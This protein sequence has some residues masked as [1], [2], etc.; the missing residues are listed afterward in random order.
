[1]YY[2][3]WRTAIDTTQKF[4]ASMESLT[5]EI[6]NRGL[7]TTIKTATTTEGAPRSIVL[8]L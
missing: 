7:A 2:S 4:D 5:R 8:S 3:F 6:G 1:M